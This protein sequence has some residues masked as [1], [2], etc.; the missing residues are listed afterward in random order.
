VLLLPIS[1]SNASSTSSVSIVENQMGL[2]STKL[3]GGADTPIDVKV[4]FARYN[5]T[6]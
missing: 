5:N 3:K 4:V 2:V 6:Y 1:I